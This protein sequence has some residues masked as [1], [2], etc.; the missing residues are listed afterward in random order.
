MQI[1]KFNLIN[2]IMSKNSKIKISHQ[3]LH[4]A[5]LYPTTLTVGLIL[6][7]ACKFLTSPPPHQTPKLGRGL[8]V[9]ISVQLKIN[10]H[11]FSESRRE[12]EW[13]RERER[14]RERGCTPHFGTHHKLRIVPEVNCYYTQ[15]SA[16][17]CSHPTLVGGM[18]E[19][20][21]GGVGIKEAALVPGA[22]ERLQYYIER[23]EMKR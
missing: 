3:K 4:C 9:S 22:L 17:P 23:R 20:G 13:R 21:G 6:L 8:R 5:P 19:V 18:S 14:E 2:L 16:L 1:I 7:H 12:G 15:P 10:T 11:T